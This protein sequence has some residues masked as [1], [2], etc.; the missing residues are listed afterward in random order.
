MS[1]R[2]KIGV[3]YPADGLLDDELWAL[4][5]EGVTPFVTREE[6]PPEDVTLEVVIRVAESRGIEDAA[7]C[8]SVIRPHVLAYF[9]T[10]ATFARGVGGDMEIAQR[11][12]AAGKAPATT[13]STATIRAL[14]AIE[15]EAVAVATPYIDEI[16]ERLVV[17][18]ESNGFTVINLE[19]MRLGSGIGEVPLG[20]I[21]RFARRA[22]R[23]GADAL[24]I[25]CTNFRTVGILE[26]LEEDL[27]KPVLSA[28]QVTMWD[29]LRI[30]GVW[31]KVSGAGS[32]Y[33]LLEEV[34]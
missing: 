2:A 11:I 24:F 34:G 25:A 18:L 10:S 13:T 19:G 31:G 22:D 21:Y 17:F 4:V 1:W 12:Q 26:E 30:A 27:G 6:V 9:C 29:A 16:N 33:G 15:A 32:L 28:N 8:L 5:P 14:Q 20:R 23:E 7:R 3:I